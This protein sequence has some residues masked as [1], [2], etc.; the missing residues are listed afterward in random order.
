MIGMK[1]LILTAVV[2]M[3]AA[4]Q[5]DVTVGQTEPDQ[6]AAAL[7]AYLGDADIPYDLLAALQN[8]LKDYNAMA[9]SKPV[10]TIPTTASTQSMIGTRPNIIKFP[11]HYITL[12]V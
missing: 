10:H 7:S 3:I 12:K 5:F 4:A 2:T 11:L 6:K 1:T 8:D 9:G